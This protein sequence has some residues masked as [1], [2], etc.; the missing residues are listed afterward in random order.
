MDLRSVVSLCA[1]FAVGLACSSPPAPRPAPPEPTHPAAPALVEP[2]PEAK[3]AASPAERLMAK[4]LARALEIQGEVARIRELAFHKVVPAER[5]SRDDFAKVVRRELDKELPRAESARISKALFH[6]GFLVDEIDLGDAMALAVTSQAA[7]YYDPD[8]G[9]FFAVSLSSDLS[10]LEIMTA[11]E[12]THGLQD[13]HFDLRKYYGERPRVELSEDAINAR[14]FIVEGEATFVMFL[15][16]AAL[17]A[18]VWEAEP[19]AKQISFTLGLLAGQMSWQQLVDSS[20]KQA[21]SI[22]GVDAEQLEALDKIPPFVLVPMLESYLGGAVT[23]ATIYADGGWKAV[24]DLYANPPSSTEQ[25]LHP[26]KLIGKRDEPQ[27]VTLPSLAAAHGEPLIDETLGELG[28]RVFLET[29]KVGDAK[30]AAAGWD[31]DRLA[32]YKTPAGLVALA[33]LIFDTARDAEEFA[34]AYTESAARRHPGGAA[35]GNSIVKR[36]GG[37]EIHV[38]QRRSAV[39]IVDSADPKIA[40]ALLARLE[41]EARFK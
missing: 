1:S 38:K 28:W 25:V 10:W 16:A 12:L 11:H 18:E 22:E 8:S 35:A 6:T 26:D 33:A 19:L 2:E 40:A 14:R 34:R 30:R 9:K 31:G 7:A 27:A 23:V 15:H 20:K 32:V 29:W 24:S 5:Q 36:G 39:Y 4:T 17:E 21:G 3:P 37:G 41:R 13:Q